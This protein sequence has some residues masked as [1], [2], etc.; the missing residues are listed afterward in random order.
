MSND[1]NTFVRV[2]EKGS[3]AAAAD[4]LG[5]TP[6]AVSKIVTRVEQRLGVQLL[7]RTTRR[8]AL[9]VEGETYFRRCRE[10]LAAIEAAEAEVTTSG[11]SLQ[12]L[13]RVNA[14]TAIGRYQ[15]AQLL[16]DFLARHPGIEIELGVT[17]RH[18]DLIAENVDV[19]VRSGQLADSTLVA[20]KVSEVRRIVCAS[21]AYLER[22]GAPETPADLLRHNCLLVTNFAHLARW[23]FYTPEGINRLAVAGDV[24]SDSGDVLV[25]LALAGHG[26]IRTL[27]S[28]AAEHLRRGR[29][30]SLLADVHV[31]EPSPIWAVTP[32]GRNRVPRV[33]AFLDFLV[34]R[35]GSAPWRVEA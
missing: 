28:T 33:R 9:T 21:P 2:V 35:L 12:G 1:M 17:D 30:V 16:P 24:T 18:V 5:L 13:I 26:I 32:S 7:T 34:E 10:I 29:L 25:D 6:S 14:G 11:K 27:E 22:R 23:P 31:D 3:F 19:A 15:I 8:I 20:R 4:D